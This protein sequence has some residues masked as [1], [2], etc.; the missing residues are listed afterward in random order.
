MLKRIIPILLVENQELIKTIKFSSPTYIGDLLNSIKIYNELEVDELAILD[1]SARRNGI[2][3][4]MIRQFA[5]ESFSPLSYGGGIKKIG[6]IERLLRLGIE[7]VVISSAS[8]D[9]SFIKEAVST[10]GSSTITIC[11]DYRNELKNKRVYINNGLVKTDY[12]LELFMSE[13]ADLGVGEFIL[14][15]IENDGM[16]SG[17]DLLLIETLTKRFS[18][19]IVICGGCRNIEDIKN[20]FDYN[21]SGAAAGSLF[22]YY[23][24][25]KGILIN[26]PTQNELSQ[27]GIKR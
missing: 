27:I 21:V 13:L 11:I 10:F 25:L 9:K 15:S 3:F 17:Y 24:K 7:K 16:Y 19:P 26:Y 18:N 12:N 14:Q 1:K 4:E 6:D 5:N 22:V 8:I 2:D 23:S 20:A